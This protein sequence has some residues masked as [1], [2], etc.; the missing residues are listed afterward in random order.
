MKRLAAII[1]STLL[2]FS[3]TACDFSN[4]SSEESESS[5]I[6][7]SANVEN[8]PAANVADFSSYDA[9][10]ETFKSIV[11]CFSEYDVEQFRKNECVYALDCSDDKTRDIYE[12]LFLSAFYH[13]K[14]DYAVA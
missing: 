10:I 12:K 14:D 13:Y 9:I 5:T 8:E 11:T 2:L 3:F 1:L 4:H 7:N 6:D